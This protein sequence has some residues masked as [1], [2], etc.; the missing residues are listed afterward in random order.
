MFFKKSNLTKSVSRVH[1]LMDLENV[2]SEGFKGCEELREEDIIHIFYTENSKKVDLDIVANHGKAHLETIKVAAG[3]QSLDMHLVSYLGYLIG[4]DKEKL[5]EYVVISKDTDFDNVI[6][7]WKQSG[8]EVSRR[9]RIDKNY[10]PSQSELN[11]KP[12]SRRQTTKPQSTKKPADKTVIKKPVNSKPAEIKKETAKV[13]L[14]QADNALNIKNDTLNTKPESIN[15]E[16]KPE[17]LNVAEAVKS[18]LKPETV[19]PDFKP[20][21]AQTEAKVESKP[22]AS[23]TDVKLESKPA[24]AKTDTKADTK[25][26]S[27]PTNKDILQILTDAGFTS[28]ITSYVVP[29]V[30]A[31]KGESNSKQ[32][33]YRQIISK[34]GQAKGLNIYN[35]IKKHI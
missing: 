10:V 15:A 2:Q 28:D 24:A 8:I 6:N 33:I 3:K 1:Y 30:G 21:T 20:E 22:A 19:K 5:D 7:F 27:K 12:K 29:L 18:D 35:H 9:H 25:V 23:K 11:S 34:F 13:K 26:D 32:L 14:K 4:L 17:T 16:I 31:N